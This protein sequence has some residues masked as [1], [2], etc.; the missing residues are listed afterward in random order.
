MNSGDGGIGVKK[1]H[2]IVISVAVVFIMVIIT[3]FCIKSFLGKKPWKDLSVDEIANVS[4][5]LTPPGV[6]LELNKFEIEELVKILHTVVI[7]K[8]DNSYTESSGQA[9]TFIITKTD[10]TQ[11]NIM[12]YNPFLVIDSVGYKTKYEPCEEL[13][14]FANQIRSLNE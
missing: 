12:A 3:M 10:G 13:N 2:I 6:T 8:E 4:V 9:V 1:K 5:T 14:S 11:M 7:Y